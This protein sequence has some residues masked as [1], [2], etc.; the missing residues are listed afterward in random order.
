M[1]NQE[2]ETLADEREGRAE[3]RESTV[4]ASVRIIKWLVVVLIVLSIGNFLRTFV[5][6]DSTDESTKASEEATE[7]AESLQVTGEEARDASLETLHELQAITKKLEEQ[8]AGEPDLQNQAIIDALAAVARI[9]GH[10]C[11]GPCPEPQS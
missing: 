2:A 8:N 6:Q 4:E 7:A 5:V 11:G 10:L 1:D 9:E 3:Q